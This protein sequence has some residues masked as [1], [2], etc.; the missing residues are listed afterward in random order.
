L[1]LDDGFT[2]RIRIKKLLDGKEIKNLDLNLPLTEL[3]SISATD[4]Q[5][6]MDALITQDESIDEKEI[7]K[8][9]KTI[10]AI[11]NTISN[12]VKNL[13]LKPRIAPDPP[14]KK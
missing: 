6:K 13:T 5:A 12:K 14:S 10:H 1:P 9:N 4:L 3:S 7:E 8:A 11:K 2:G